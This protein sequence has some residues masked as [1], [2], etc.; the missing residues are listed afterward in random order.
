MWK[1]FHA[2]N[3]ISCLIVELFYLLLWRWKTVLFKDKLNDYC[4]SMHNYKINLCTHQLS[5][6]RAVYKRSDEHL[7]NRLKCLRL[8]LVCSQLSYQG[9]GSGDK[10]MGQRCDPGLS[11]CL[12][13]L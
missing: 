11:T 13:G 1:E 4:A 5:T 9:Q 10:I 8:R 2:I 12:P 6:R 7:K 3:R